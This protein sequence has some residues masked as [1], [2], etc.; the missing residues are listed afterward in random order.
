MN[1]LALPGTSL[2]ARHAA[3]PGVANDPRL[4]IETP[5]FSTA[6]FLIRGS[7]LSAVAVRP[8]M[9]LGALRPA[10]I[11]SLLGLFPWCSSGCLE[12][13]PVLAEK[14]ARKTNKGWD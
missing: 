8:S 4:S 6:V 11:R 12:T 2:A 5:R 14:D 1:G 10:V 13:V 9:R 7:R 3:M